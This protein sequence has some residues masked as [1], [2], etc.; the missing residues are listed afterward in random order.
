MV[1]GF[2]DLDNLF[3]RVLARKPGERDPEMAAM[4]NKIPYLNS[5]L[6]EP[7]ELEQITIFISNL[8][9]HTQLPIISSTVLKDNKGKKRTGKLSGLQYL[10]DFLDAYDFA[11]EGSEEIQEENKTL[12]NASV[13]GLI[14][15]KLN[16]YKDG[17][18]FTPG[19]ITMYMCCLLY[20][21]PSPRDS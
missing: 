21:S 19:F 14:F 10:F 18:F 11:G 3:F 5:S 9:D 4:F 16:G 20:T 1:D 15:E 17:S 12:I 6:F 8:Q 7:T 13:L 2:D